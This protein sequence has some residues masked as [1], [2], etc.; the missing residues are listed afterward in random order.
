MRNTG[1]NRPY[2]RIA[3]ALMSHGR[4]GRVRIARSDD[5]RLESMA[6]SADLDGLEDDPRELGRMMRSMSRETGEEMPAEFD[7]VVNRL[8][9]TITRGYR[10]GYA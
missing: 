4:I 3:R 10:A 1:K 5:S 2:A 9:G 6:D 8:E 7:E